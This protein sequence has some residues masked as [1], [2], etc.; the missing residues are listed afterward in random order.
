[1]LQSLS[2]LPISFRRRKF[3]VDAGATKVEDLDDFLTITVPEH[4][5]DTMKRAVRDLAAGAAGK[6][7]A[8]YYAHFNEF[9]NPYSGKPFWDVDSP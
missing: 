1:L 3:L 9:P 8:E 6:E 5:I 2:H 7:I 4:L